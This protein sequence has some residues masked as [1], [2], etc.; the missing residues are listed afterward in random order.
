LVWCH[1]YYDSLDARNN[2]WGQGAGEPDYGWFQGPVIWDDYNQYVPDC[3]NDSLPPDPVHTKQIAQKTG[4]QATYD[5]SPN[6]PN[7]FNP[8][9][10]FK[11]SIAKECHVKIVI[12]NILGQ[13][14]T[15]LVDEVKSAGNHFAM[16]DGKNAQG[17]DVASGLYF[18]VIQAGEFTQSKKMMII[19]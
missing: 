18:Y 16:W 7:P 12:C 3:V 6:W 2:N 1:D 5:L 8:A 19:K 15:T 11:Y 13:K 4:Q 14:V 17:R 10:S 9:T